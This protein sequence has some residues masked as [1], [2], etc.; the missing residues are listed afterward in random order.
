MAA[1]TAAMIAAGP[2]VERRVITLSRSSARRRGGAIED[3][4]GG[5]GEDEDERQDI[6]DFADRVGEEEHGPVEVVG[7][8]ADLREGEQR[9][10]APEGRRAGAEGPPGEVGTDPEQDDVDRQEADGR[11]LAD[12]VTEGHR[13]SSFP[14]GST[15]RASGTRRRRRRRA[16]GPCRRGRRSGL[17]ARQRRSRWSP[18]AFRTNARQG[19]RRARRRSSPR[20]P[21]RGREYAGRWSGWRAS[22]VL[23]R[24]YR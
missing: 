16:P 23:R 18:P 5:R 22:R 20:R 6:E 15:G 24:L 21:S 19:R 1:R 8:V 17:R 13:S 7:H 14:A 3:R 10:R 9:E 12:E 4:P 2:R 11:D